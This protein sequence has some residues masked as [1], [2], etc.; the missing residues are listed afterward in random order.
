MTKTKF[1]T[2]LTPD[3][4]SYESHEAKIRIFSDNEF[5][6]F[7]RELL[8]ERAIEVNGEWITEIDLFN[9]NQ[10][11]KKEA[12]EFLKKKIDINIDTKE[13]LE[14]INTLF[15]EA[16][17][18]YNTYLFRSVPQEL[19]KIVFT[20]S[21]DVINFL[22]IAAQKHSY[23]QIYCTILKISIVVNDIMDNPS[24]QN[25][26]KKWKKLIKDTIL[27]DMQIMDRSFPKDTPFTDWYYVKE[28]H[29][30]HARAI[31]FSLRFRGKSKE[32]SAAKSIIDPKQNEYTIGRDAIWMEFIL[33]EKSDILF[34]L[35]YIYIHIF[36]RNIE[37]FRQKF[38][39]DKWDITE[40]LKRYGKD[41]DHD[42][43]ELLKNEL[44]V[45]VKPLTWKGERYKDIKF[46]WVVEIAESDDENAIKIPHWVEVR[47]ILE[48][49]KNN[50][51]MADHRIRE[52]L[53][54]LFAMCRLQWYVTEVYIQRVIQKIKEKYPK[55]PHSS[56]N[57]FTYYKQ[58]LFELQ[59]KD[60]RKTKLF[61]TPCRWN[62]L[63]WTQIYP[64]D[65]V[66]AKDFEWSVIP[67]TI[68]K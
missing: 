18:F 2:G 68:K 27:N 23:R 15:K 62:A 33:E 12:K 61:T 64:D 16:L 34:M 54:R 43:K 4:S 51:G 28:L 7:W 21:D 55:L 59:T 48:N 36:K 49:N 13:W 25:L 6:D 52:W 58:Q 46:V 67:K 63:S 20:S 40:L 3:F 30:G 50:A 32:S 1:Q 38:L 47:C 26:D 11:N 37:E 42:F 45:K 57:M 17:D 14:K 41:L 24:L 8:M 44:G 65:V 31:R 5:P 22:N 35:E 60:S 19:Q 53:K 29:N 56:E 10:M 9:I 66:R 39:F